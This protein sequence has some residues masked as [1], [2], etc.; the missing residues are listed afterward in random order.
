[1]KRTPWKLPHRTTPLKLPRGTSIMEVTYLN[2]HQG[3]YLMEL[4]PRKL[5]SGT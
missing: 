3:R 5:P 2:S 4:T 1:M